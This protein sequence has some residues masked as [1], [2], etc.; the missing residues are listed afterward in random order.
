VSSTD[1]AGRIDLSR[2][3][4]GDWLVVRARGFVEEER[5]LAG[6]PWSEPAVL[7]LRREP[8]WLEGTLVDDTGAPIG[9]VGLVLKAGSPR[10]YA[11]VETVTTRT[12]PDGR[13]VLPG[14]RDRPPAEASFSIASDAHGSPADGATLAWSEWE[15]RGWPR[16]V[17]DRKAML[18]LTVERWTGRST[19]KAAV[20]VT[21]R[22]VEAGSGRSM[23]R[24]WER[25]T[26]A[27]TEDEPLYLFHLPAG[28]PI[29][30]EAAFGHDGYWSGGR[31]AR[32]HG[33]LE[34][35]ALAPGERAE[36]T[37]VLE[38]LDAPF[39]TVVVL[40]EQKER[41]PSARVELSSEGCGSLSVPAHGGELRIG[42]PFSDWT[43]TVRAPGHAVW[44]GEISGPRA[45]EATLPVVLQRGTLDFDTIEVRVVDRN[46][47]PFEGIAVKISGDTIQQGTTDAEGRCVQR[48]FNPMRDYRVWVG[49]PGSQ[50][51]PLF[52]FEPRVHPD[53]RPGSAPLEFREV[54]PSSIA[55]VL[56]PGAPPQARVALAGWD[57]E[58][59]HARLVRRTQSPDPLGGFEFTGLPAGRYRIEA[60]VSGEDVVEPLELDLETGQRIAGIELRRP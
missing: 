42:R 22:P 37:L 9:G 44:E 45:L 20:V 59:E 29:S 55:G 23:L 27:G 60:I 28:V 8:T 30:V 6:L 36:R 3:R 25:G 24:M 41:I 19:R 47:A 51:G 18:V 35:D 34:V 11:G 32:E 14:R 26:D 46:G 21:G 39:V 48:G 16:L 33:R 49:D 56:P 5:E 12:A 15:R 58:D 7:E 40:D 52:V 1:A 50:D 53:V 54:V 2:G 43:L 10:S 57:R 4:D 38:R 17:A 13:F 31:A